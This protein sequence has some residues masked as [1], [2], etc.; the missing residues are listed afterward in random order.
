MFDQSPWGPIALLVIIGLLGVVIVAIWWFR[1]R[2]FVASTPE[3]AEEIAHLP[4]TSLQRRAWWAFGLGLAIVI[5]I[6]AVVA[7]DGVVEYSNNDSSRTIVVVLALVFLVVYLVMLVPTALRAGRGATDERDLR[8]MATAP[9]IQAG[10][11]LVTV[12]AWTLYLTEEFRDVGVPTEYM[13]PIFGSVFLVYMLSH[14]AGILIG[15]WLS[16][17]YAQG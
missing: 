12:M 7:P 5:A 16:R 8:V 1:S 3:E 4:M 2:R 11:M 9:S 14:A 15:Y 6:V 13:Y 17:G 10:A